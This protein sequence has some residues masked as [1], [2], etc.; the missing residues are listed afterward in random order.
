MAAREHTGLFRL[1]VLLTIPSAYLVVHAALE[2]ATVGAV[3]VAAGPMAVT[4][5]AAIISWV[6]RQEARS[7][8]DQL[9]LE[10]ANE[11]EQNV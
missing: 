10:L 9:D 3:V 11:R 1:F 4:T 2:A 5:C 7:E 6:A 8:R